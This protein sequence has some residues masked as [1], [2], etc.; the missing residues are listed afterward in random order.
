MACLVQKVTESGGAKKSSN[1]FSQD[2]IVGKTPNKFLKVWIAVIKILSI[3]LPYLEG[4]NSFWEI[5]YQKMYSTVTWK[6][7]QGIDIS[8]PAIEILSMV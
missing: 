8:V 5:L 7:H 6:E 3:V 2:L 4:K 1:L